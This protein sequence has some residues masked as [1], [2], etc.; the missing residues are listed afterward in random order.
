LF[1]R[2]PHAPKT[3]FQTRQSLQDV[4]EIDARVLSS[5]NPAKGGAESGPLAQ[6]P[7]GTHA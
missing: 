2:I 4:A 5:L 6:I 1:W 7:G 3:A